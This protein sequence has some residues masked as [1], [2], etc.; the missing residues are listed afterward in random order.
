MDEVIFQ[1]GDN[2]WGQVTVRFE[3]WADG[4]ADDEDVAWFRAIVVIS[5]PS[6]RGRLGANLTVDDIAGLHDA[7]ESVIAG[8]TS[9]VWEPLEPWLVL[10]VAV[11]DDRASVHGRAQE[12]IGYGSTLTFGGVVE[13]SALQDL[14][15]KTRDAVSSMRKH[16]DRSS[17]GS[18]RR[19]PQA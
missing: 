16:Q 7:V 19:H 13:L 11:V 15:A 17:D 5:T 14:L 3:S 9:V 6:F 2:T 12:Q 1:L 18:D 10:T 8:T 4:G